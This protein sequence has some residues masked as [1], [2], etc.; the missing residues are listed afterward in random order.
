MD[1]KLGY[2]IDLSENISEEL[3]KGAQAEILT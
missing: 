3:K 1:N 2:D